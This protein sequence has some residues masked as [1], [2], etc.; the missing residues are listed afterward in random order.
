MRV[1]VLGSPDG[2]C[3]DILIYTG[4]PVEIYAAV[5]AL[6]ARPAGHQTRSP[7]P[8]RVFAVR[9]GWCFDLG[10][11]RAQGGDYSVISGRPA[12]LTGLSLKD[13]FIDA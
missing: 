11:C 5:V 10:S 1:W 8:V 9:S 3:L 12:F 13:R 7:S 4:A 2:R 6:P